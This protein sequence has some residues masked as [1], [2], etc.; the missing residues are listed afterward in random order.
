MAASIKQVRKQMDTAL[1]PSSFTAKVLF[2][3]IQMIGQM[4]RLPGPSQQTGF[5][6][7]LA[8]KNASS[9]MYAV[10]M[11]I[12]LS[13]IIFLLGLILDI[14]KYKKCMRIIDSMHVGYVCKYLLIRGIKP[15]PSVL[16]KL[17][18]LAS[19]TPQQPPR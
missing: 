4:Y 6:S 19:E 16:D 9:R 5:V 3:S 8:C 15:L 10:T 17:L 1:L 18:N 12:I 2:N 7:T 14:F 11:C 13:I